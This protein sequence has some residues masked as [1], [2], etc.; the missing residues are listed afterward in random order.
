[1]LLLF[2]RLRVRFASLLRVRVFSL[3]ERKRFVFASA[4]LKLERMQAILLTVR[5]RARASSLFECERDYERLQ[6]SSGC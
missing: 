5:L 3:L 4:R 2:E 1:M 6:K